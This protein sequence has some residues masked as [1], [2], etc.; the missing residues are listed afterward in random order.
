MASTSAK[1]REIARQKV[2]KALEKY[3]S[4][5]QRYGEAYD[6]NIKLRRIDIPDEV[7]KRLPERVIN[8]YVDDLAQSD[9][10]AFMDG[11]KHDY[12]WIEGWRQ[13][14][15]SGGWLTIVP[16]AGAM[17]E[18]GR[19]EDLRY[20][21]KRLSDLEEIEEQVKSAKKAHVADLESKA[22]WD[23]VSPS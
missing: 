11:L 15:R 6:F 4:S 13:E 7:R 10:E 12:P 5:H 16:E 22:W 19:I 14:G 17:D 23:E 20:A 9:I 21:K 18:Y 1:T 8:Q 3:L 2:A